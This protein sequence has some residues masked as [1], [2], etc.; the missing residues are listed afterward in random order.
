MGGLGPAEVGPVAAAGEQRQADVRAVVPDQR[1]RLHEQVDVAALQAAAA[2][3]ADAREELRLGD[4]DARGRGGERLLRLRQVRPAFEQVA[5]HAHRH[6]RRRGQGGRARG[7]AEAGGV[8][9]N[10]DGDGVFELVALRLQA[11]NFRLGGGHLG[12]RL[13]LFKFAAGAGGDAGLGDL[14]GFAA[15]GDGGAH[16][17]DLLVEGAQAE[18][19]AGDL[20]LEGEQDVVHRVL[21]GRRFGA[22]GFDV[23]ADLAPEIELPVEIAHGVVGRAVVHQAVERNRA[24]GV[25]RGAL[26][27]GGGDGVEAGQEIRAAVADDGARLVEARQGGLELLVAGGGL[28]LKLVEFGV[29]EQLPPLAF[30][31]VRGRARFAPGDA[32]EAGRGFGR[33]PGVIRADLGE[34]AGGQGEGKQET[35][36]HGGRGHWAL[37][38]RLGA[39]SSTWTGFLRPSF[40][41]R[42]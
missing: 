15:Q 40:I 20:G 38:C 1:G 16:Q 35:Q 31:Q 18:V 10:Q 36:G 30:R 26:A 39:G 13:R 4:A 23:A 21:G 33:R 42:T 28:G 6:G 25:F 9:A 22:A 29:A 34:G 11:G 14:E 19:V 12:L 2:D 27:F 8:G 41:T 17:L 7:D 32:F 3:E 24:R 5:G 37:G